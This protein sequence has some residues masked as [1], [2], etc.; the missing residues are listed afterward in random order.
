[1]G[2]RVEELEDPELKRRFRDQEIAAYRRALDVDPTDPTAWNNLAACFGDMADT[3][4]DPQRAE[5]LR[6]Q[7][8]AGYENAVQSDP[9]FS[10]AWR[11]LAFCRVRQ[12]DEA[13]A[14]GRTDDRNHFREQAIEA[15]RRA[16]ETDPEDGQSWYLLS[17]TLLTQAGEIGAAPGPEALEAARRAVEYGEDSYNL[18]CALARA[19]QT[20][21]ALKELAGCLE[22]YEVEPEY[23]S[24]D[25]DL[26]ALWN[27]RRFQALVEAPR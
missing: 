22:R 8:I 1:L 3:E 17:A 6:A 16:T 21:E 26:Q 20:E 19:G 27:D 25:P 11:G 4:T 5:D 12:A 18:V 2:L 14:A 10:R 9:T 23:A 15:C 13:A 24:Q 7:E